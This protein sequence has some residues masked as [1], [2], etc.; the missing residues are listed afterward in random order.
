MDDLRIVDLSWSSDRRL[1]TEDTEGMKVS[2]AKRNREIA[3]RRRRAKEGE[4]RTLDT[5]REKR[6]RCRFRL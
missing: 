5:K 3:E 2:Q 1:L 4:P 6:R